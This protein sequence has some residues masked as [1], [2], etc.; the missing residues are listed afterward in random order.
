MGSVLR[1]FDAGPVH[2]EVL[3][4]CTAEHQRP[5]DPADGALDRFS[6]QMR[7]SDPE[8]LTGAYIEDGRLYLDV[9]VSGAS[10][11]VVVDLRAAALRA[12]ELVRHG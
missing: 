4:V 3:T 2:L 6:A 8:P 1:V 11:T 5:V 7:Q 9:V 12:A 10:V